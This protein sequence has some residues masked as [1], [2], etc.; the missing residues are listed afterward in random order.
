MLSYKK[1]SERFLFTWEY[2]NGVPFSSND[3]KTIAPKENRLLVWGCLFIYPMT[4]KKM[5]DFSALLEAFHEQKRGEFSKTLQHFDQERNKKNLNLK[6]EEHLFGIVRD[7]F[8]K[9]ET[10]EMQLKALRLAQV[11]LNIDFVQKHYQELW[12]LY[13]ATLFHPNGN[14]RHYGA[15]LLSDYLMWI[16]FL[17]PFEK[18]KKSVVDKE[19]EKMEQ[20]Y[21]DKFV[22]MDF[23]HHHYMN[24]EAAELDKDDLPDPESPYFPHST[25]TKDK[26][27]KNIRRA[28][29][30]M[31]RSDSLIAYLAHKY[32]QPPEELFPPFPE[33]VEFPVGEGEANNP[34]RR[35]LRAFWTWM[36]EHRQQYAK[37]LSAAYGTYWR[38]GLV[39]SQEHHWEF[40][41]EWLAFDFPV[42]GFIEPAS[43]RKSFLRLFV[44]NGFPGVEE[45]DLDFA[46]RF[47]L[48][49]THLVEVQGVEKG[50]YIVVRDLFDGQEYELWDV[51]ASHGAK[52]GENLFLRMAE[53]E[54]GKY[55]GAGAQLYKLFSAQVEMLLFLIGE[56][57]KAGNM[58]IPE[59]F[60]W[61]SYIVYR[62][63]VVGNG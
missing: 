7:T 32:D 48:A 27:L 59:F 26:F 41:F 17:L 35:V 34:M 24:E 14:I 4:P 33:E 5:C 61:N 56:T 16:N 25:E 23:I 42:N 44:E 63:L 31:T 40:F 11:L 52:P 30:E 46:K 50:M 54:P 2:T 20:W 21:W 45:R 15:N 19:G 9:A 49:R 3:E 29:E 58:S 37:D 43:E 6:E 47:A 22:Q 8:D 13:E 12:F 57:A 1:S 62:E 18:R 53:S 51:A 36:E 39:P 38:E 55:I 10:T 28:L 60:Q